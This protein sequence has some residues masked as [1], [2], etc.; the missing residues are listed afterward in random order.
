M[1]LGTALVRLLR[2]ATAFAL[3]CATLSPAG[4]M[5]ANPDVEVTTLA[6]SGALGTAD[7]AAL[8][9]SFVFPFGVAFGDDGTLYVSDA[10]AQR[11]RAV[12]RDGRVRT[13]AGAGELSGKNFWVAGGYRDGTGAAARFNRPA[14][15]AWHDGA[16]YVAD[17]NNH[18][19]RKVLPNGVVTTYA[20]SPTR[21]GSQDGPLQSASFERPVGV[22]FD[23]RGTLYVAD[24]SSAIRTISPDGRVGSIVGF[25]STPLNVAT[26]ET[27]R[28]T[29]LFASD[30]LGVVR[31]SPDGTVE[32]F[33]TPDAAHIPHRQVQGL[34]PIGYP[35]GVAAF[36]ADTVLFTDVRGSAVRYIDWT[37][38]APH[39]LA[40]TDTFDAAASS[41]AFRD[42]NGDESRVDA[43]TG[44]TV[45]P[46]GD[47]VF[48]DSGS[49]RIRAIRGLD[50]THDPKLGSGELLTARADPSAYRIAFIGASNV[51]TY[52]RWSDSLAGVVEAKLTH[53]EHGR[54]FQVIPYAFPGA[55]L[56]AQVSVATQV[57]TETEGAS[58][59]VVEIDPNSLVGFAGMK[60]GS[61]Q[62][63]LV[64]AA[65][66][67]T[68]VL[69]RK[70]RGWN[71][72][73][74]HAGMKLVVY[75]VPRPI[76]L[77][78]AEN[79]WNTVL[80]PASTEH[81]APSDRIGDL[82][83][84]AI[85]AAGVSC[86]DGWSLFQD[87]E[88]SPEH[89]ALFGTQDEHWSAHGRAVLGE[90]LAAYLE[91]LAPWDAAPARR[92]EPFSRRRR[93][94]TRRSRS[95]G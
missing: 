93:A 3:L 23:R 56:T 86:F 65:P 70:F 11:I 78:P 83:N 20:G 31:R 14:G 33:A 25:A 75:T 77:S 74:E 58:L 51:W 15:I 28:G 1:S 88:R 85:K 39:L 30:L 94:R 91:R 67:W 48:A 59:I 69:T 10:G 46:N 92:G 54:R 62:D 60:A 34:Q 16:L 4:A 52:V 2:C 49:R 57:F 12:E 36:D 71:D 76:D 43:P 5:T 50:R 72:E 82:V 87:E 79:A 64:A 8:Q 22:A 13:I 37:A 55:S 21:V 6:G 73:L 35:F 84:A 89:A 42:G 90:A 80:S 66:R 38:A 44:I 24:P 41:A 29:V 63:E 7:G 95:R 45:A 53:D 17:T 68:A 9:A 27:S 19:I 26:A 32:R 18:C 61:T 81:V 40:G 47:V